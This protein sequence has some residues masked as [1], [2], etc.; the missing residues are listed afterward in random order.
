IFDYQDDGIV[1]FSDTD[2]LEKEIPS[3]DQDTVLAVK[4]CPTKAL[5]IL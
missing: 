5:T 1:K 2:N 4:S 3:S